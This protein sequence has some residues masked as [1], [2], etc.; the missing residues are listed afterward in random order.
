[1]LATVPVRQACIDQQAISASLA[2]L[3][4]YLAGCE[5]LLVI[6]GPTYKERLWCAVEVFT[7]VRMGGALER[8][9]V[10]PLATSGDLGFG[11]FAVEDANCH[12]HKDKAKLLTAIEAAFGDY[13]PFNALVRKLLVTAS[14][15]VDA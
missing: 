7:F 8:I 15:G 9:R 12:D 6:A 11:R 10:A 13:A 14:Q 5:Q 4:V 2:C 3:P 1:M